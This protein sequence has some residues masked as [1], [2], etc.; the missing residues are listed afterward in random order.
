MTIETLIFQKPEFELLRLDAAD[1]QPGYVI[2][3]RKTS[4]QVETH[5]L[6]QATPLYE[7]YDTQTETT[8]MR[9][10]VVEKKKRKR[11]KK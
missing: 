7:W 3:I 11:K 10:I 9:P 6:M 2:V 4:D 8:I 1:P 5:V